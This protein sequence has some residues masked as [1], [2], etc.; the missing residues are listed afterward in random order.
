MIVLCGLVTAIPAFAFS[1]QQQKQYTAVAQILFRSQQLGEQ[2]AGLP[3]INTSNPQPETDTN[4]QLAGL[5]RVA[6]ETASALGYRLSQQQVV[7][8]VS[9]SPVS[10]TQL[11]K[12]SAT[13]ASPLFAARLAN[14]YARRVIADRMSTDRGYYA[15]ALRAVNL[16]FN[17]LSPAQQ[18][19]NRGC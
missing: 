8:S 6:A 9:V 16:Q 10:D 18:S 17:A 12:V 19:E 14:T 2:A 15:S 11:A 1:K 13:S 4:L 5:P 3:V 7:T